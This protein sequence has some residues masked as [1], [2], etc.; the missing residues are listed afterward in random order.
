MSESS[1]TFGCSYPGTGS[2]QSSANCQNKSFEFMAL[3]LATG[4]NLSELTN[5]V[6]G[7]LFHKAWVDA[8]EDH[9]RDDCVLLMTLLFSQEQY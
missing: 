9:R 1:E 6:G 5:A 3:I 8:I 7:T 4:T 2:L